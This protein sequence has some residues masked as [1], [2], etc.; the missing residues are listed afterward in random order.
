MAKI[1]RSG[2]FHVYLLRCADGSLYSGYTPDLQRRIWLHNQGR[3]AKYT[4]GRRPVELVWSREYRYFRCA[5]A[6]ERR[7]KRLTRQQKERLI[8]G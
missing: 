3:G 4:R 2:R 1:K 6:A 5:L 8:G 7:L